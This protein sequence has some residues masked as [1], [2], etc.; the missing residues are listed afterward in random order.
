MAG[1]TFSDLYSPSIHVPLTT[2]LEK[3][4]Q[5]T[6]DGIAAQDFERGYLCKV[7]VLGCRDKD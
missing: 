4:L 5:T 7:D 2:I 1:K 3:V 6:C